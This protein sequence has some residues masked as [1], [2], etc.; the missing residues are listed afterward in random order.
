MFED[1]L[2]ARS[3][4]DTV[5]RLRK[6]SGMTLTDLAQRSGISVSALSKIENDLTSPTYDTILRLALG[7]DV[8][9]TELF[10]SNVTGTVNGRREITRKG[11]GVVQPTPHYEYEMLASSLATKAFTPLVTKVRARSVA[12]FHEL[13][14]HQGEEFFYVLSGRVVLHSEHYAPVELG[15]GD[16]AYFDSSMGHALVSVS[17]K[18]ALILW[19]A[20]RVSGVLAGGHDCD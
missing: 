2:K 18:D 13:H 8:D 15:E 1:Y 14:S 11:E 20:T 7:L 12:E 5:H 19:I 16:S 17:P 9:I 3:I 10:G 4:S 6:Q